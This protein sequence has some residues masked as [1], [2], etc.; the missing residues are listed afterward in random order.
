MAFNS[1][2]L[3]KITSVNDTEID[4]SDDHTSISSLTL[5]N[6]HGTNAVA[7]E[8][9]IETKTGATSYI[10]DTDSNVNNSPS[11]YAV[12]GGSLTV[13]INNGG[14]A[15]TSD[16]FLSKKVYKSDGTLFGTCTTFTSAAEI[17][18]SGGIENAM[19]HADSLYTPTKYYII[20]DVD[21]PA[22]A[23]L[24]LERDEV[25][26]NQSEFSLWINASVANVVDVIIR[27]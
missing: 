17:I 20:K 6:I 5:S 23:T 14:T 18:F 8:L 1:I 22:G 3:Q 13:A 4:L 12:T 25:N 11:G 27:P 9:Y 2:N 26:I 19:A 16:M 21:I 7:V 24:K 15:G 10:T